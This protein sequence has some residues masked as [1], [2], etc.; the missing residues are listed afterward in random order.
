M[1]IFGKVRK[2]FWTAFA[3]LAILATTVMAVVHPVFADIG[4]MTSTITDWLPII[5]AFAMLSMVLGM[6]KKFGK[7]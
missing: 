4:D 5:I 7:V 6:L 3:F 2:L 1:K